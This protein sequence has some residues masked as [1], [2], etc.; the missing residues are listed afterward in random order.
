MTSLSLCIVKSYI[1][2]KAKG[3]SYVV[4]L[5]LI[6]IKTVTKDKLLEQNTHSKSSVVTFFEGR[7]FI[8]CRLLDEEPFRFSNK[9]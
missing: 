3:H 5:Y 2:I 8:E 1:V 4:L 9:N 7:L 6:G